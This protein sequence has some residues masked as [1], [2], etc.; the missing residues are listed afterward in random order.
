MILSAR[1][2]EF[3]HLFNINYKCEM[4]TYEQE[5]E[6]AMM[7]SKMFC[8]SK[9]YEQEV[10]FYDENNKQKV[11]LTRD[12]LGCI[13]LYEYHEGHISADVRPMWQNEEQHKL[14]ILEVL[15]IIQEYVN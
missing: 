2:S 11:C 12:V 10:M 15:E 13:T 5:K 14:T 9:T 8:A 6:V 3:G 4:N 7:V 1:K